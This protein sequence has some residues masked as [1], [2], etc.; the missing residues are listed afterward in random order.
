M[1]H[2]TKAIEMYLSECHFTSFSFTS[3]GY[4]TPSLPP[5]TDCLP[6]TCHIIFL[7]YPPSH[8]PPSLLGFSTPLSLLSTSTSCP[9]PCPSHFPDASFSSPHVPLRSICSYAIPEATLMVTLR[10]VLITSIVTL[11]VST[12]LGLSSYSSSRGWIRPL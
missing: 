9:H 7:V 8:S 4:N 1:Q 12:S 11:I 2:S 5:F 3:L 6:S 10:P